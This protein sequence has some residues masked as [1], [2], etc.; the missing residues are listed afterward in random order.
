VG[1]LRNLRVGQWAAIR[2]GVGSSDQEIFGQAAGED[3]IPAGIR[4]R[5]GHLERL[6]VRCTL[7]VLEGE[8]TAELIF[9]SRYGNVDMLST[10]L[11]SIAE[12]QLM[13]PMV[14]SGSVHN[15]APGLVGQIRKERLAHT[16]LAAGAGTFEAG[17]IESYARLA[18][19]DA[20]DV[21]LVYADV[22]LPDLYGNFEDERV[23]SLAL[24][25]RLNLADDCDPKP[26]PAPPGR[27]G[28]LD[29]LDRLQRGQVCL[30]VEAGH[31]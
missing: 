9:C 21:T 14:F 4:R 31:G 6:A 16:A 25:V 26:V 15:A 23:P 1:Q 7:G 30:S 5:M 12:H 18:S 3:A 20:D 13:S 11:R 28:V 17:L 29:V 8:P 24:A 22:A 27:Q 10:L 2:I 19:D